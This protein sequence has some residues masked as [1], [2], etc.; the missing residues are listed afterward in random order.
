MQDLKYPGK[1]DISGQLLL[2]ILQEQPSPSITS[3][4]QY[5]SFR[6]RFYWLH[7]AQSNF[8]T[9]AVNDTHAPWP[10][11]C[12]HFSRQTTLAI[13]GRKMTRR[14]RDGKALYNF[15]ALAERHPNSA[16][17]ESLTQVRQML[18]AFP[19][20][21]TQLILTPALTH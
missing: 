13:V 17:A 10:S 1:Q 11:H 5:S 16:A 9:L 4:L 14:T 20:R 19:P 3:V 15:S 18:A 21:K 12:E 6:N 7:L 8:P 2:H